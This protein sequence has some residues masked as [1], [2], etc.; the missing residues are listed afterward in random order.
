MALAKSFDEARGNQRLRNGDVTIG[1]HGTT[2]GTE[3]FDGSEGKPHAA[4]LEFS[5]GRSSTPHFHA[6]DQFQISIKG[7]AKM[8]RHDM[9]TYG[10]HFSRAYTPYGPFV[11]DK[12]VGLV[13]FNLHSLVDRRWR[14]NHL[15]QE[16]EALRQVP[17]RNPWQITTHARFPATHQ[18]DVVLQDISGLQDEFGLGGYS[19]SMKSNARCK[20]PDCSRGEGQYLVLVEGSILHEEKELKA[21][22]LVFV[23]PQERAYEARAGA[24]GARALVIN[25]PVDTN[26]VAKA[27]ANGRQEAGPLKV[28]GCDLCSFVYDEEAGLANEGFAPGTRWDQVPDDWTCPDCGATKHEFHSLEF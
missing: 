17:N 2:L 12:D 14:A 21:P 16:A 27:G 5:P 7:R 19:L 20:T 1:V 28:M 15:P 10:V 18:E 13:C 26:K 9:E 8:G 23:Y 24:S 6:V 11:S 22:A 25:F 4:M 3:F